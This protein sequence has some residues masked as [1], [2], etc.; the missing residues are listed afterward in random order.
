[1]SLP[2]ITPAMLCLKERKEKPKSLIE[3]A[4]HVTTKEMLGGGSKSNKTWTQLDKAISVA[5]GTPWLGMQTHKAKVLFMNMEILE[6][7]FMERL[8]VVMEAKKVKVEDCNLDLWHLRGHSEG[9]EAFLTKIEAVMKDSQ[10]ELV[11]MDPVYKLYGDADENKATDIIKML[12]RFERF[13]QASKCALSY[14][15]HFAKG[16][17]HE[18]SAIDRVSGSGAFA[19]DADTITTLTRHKEEHCFTVDFILRNCPEIDPFV[20]EWRYPIMVRRPDLDPNTLAQP[21][22]TGRGVSAC[23]PDD[24]LDFLP[25]EGASNKVWMVKATENLG[26][27]PRTFQ[28]KLKQLKKQGKVNNANDLWVP[29]NGK[30]I[31]DEV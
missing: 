17:Q 13:V 16:P 11:I 21:G 7:F 1:M 28:N 2:P 30:G 23:E 6:P 12:N 8:Q 15:S 31:L 26:I 25:H 4:L 10:Y 27:S 22:K 3:G 20:V 5:S 18:K 24:M 29:V 19:R 9:Y 14:S